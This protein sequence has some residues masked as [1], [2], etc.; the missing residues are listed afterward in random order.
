M[1]LVVLRFVCCCD[2]WFA[3]LVIAALSGGVGG[4]R[5]LVFLVCGVY[6]TVF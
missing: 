3:C 6:T 4:V 2:C 1:V 5:C